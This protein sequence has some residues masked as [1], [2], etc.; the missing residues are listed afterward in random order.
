MVFQL[1][2]FQG[3]RYSL[4]NYN[5]VGIE[6][7]YAD[8]NTFIVD[9]PR[10]HGLTKPIP[11]NKIITL[12]SLADSTVLV[13][14][15]GF[16]RPV[17]A[18]DKLAKSDNSKFRVIGKGYGRIALLSVVDSSWV[19]VEGLGGMA[20]VRLEK[21]VNVELPTMFQWQDML[22][23]DLMLMSLYTHRY[24][25][26]DPHARSLSSADAPGTR[27]D[28]KDGACFTWTLINP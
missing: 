7:G 16:L 4:F 1:R 21:Q 23:G 27:P 10:A 12:T 20:E 22:Q 24:L 14:W 2:T 15:K 18:T 28:R 5:T 3:V 25:F 13:N 19:T 8:F 17:P 11:Y 26:V 6:G 9:E